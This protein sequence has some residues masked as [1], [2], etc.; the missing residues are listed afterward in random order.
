MN[1]TRKT[2]DVILATLNQPIAVSGF[3]KLVTTAFNQLASD[4]Y[5]IVRGRRLFSLNFIPPCWFFPGS[6]TVYSLFWWAA[7]QEVRLPTFKNPLRIVY[8]YSASYFCGTTTAQLVISQNSSSAS[9]SHASSR[10]SS[11]SSAMKNFTTDISDTSRMSGSFSNTKKSLCWI[12]KPTNG[13]STEN[14]FFFLGN[15]ASASVRILRRL[16]PKYHWTRSLK[17]KN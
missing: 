3:P 8:R 11:A 1:G 16:P 7:V 10:G 15:L 2:I 9:I 6:K 4:T 5:D 14:L 12:S 13:F 17:R